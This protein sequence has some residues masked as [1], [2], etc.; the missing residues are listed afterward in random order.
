MADGVLLVAN[1][2]MTQSKEIETAKEIIEQ[3]E[4]NIV[5]MVVNNG[6]TQ[7]YSKVYLPSFKIDLSRQSF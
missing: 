1:P 4:H 2:S 5:G 3:F 7:D 6:R